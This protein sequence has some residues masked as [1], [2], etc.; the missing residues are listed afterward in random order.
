MN[1]K[2]QYDIEQFFNLSLDMLCIAGMDGYFKHINPSFERTLGWSPEEL[3]AETFF[4]FIHPD[5]LGPTLR[6]V[7]KLRKGTSSA[8]FE[9][10]YR[11]SDGSYRY[12]AWTAV[13]VKETR[14]IY[15]IARD[16]TARKE[17]EEKMA[18]L[19]TEL[20]TA[21]D[22]L[23]RLASADPLTG[24]RNRRVFNEQLTQL[25]GVIQRAGKS[26][27]LLMADVDHF[28]Q[29]NDQFGH[30]SGDQILITIAALLMQNTRVSDIVARYG[31]EEFAVI[32]PNTSAKAAILIGE[33]L[34]LAVQNHPWESKPVAV[35]I[36]ISTASFEQNHPTGIDANC[37]TKLIAEADQALYQSKTRGRNRT[38]HIANHSR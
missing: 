16:V 35:S 19:A 34:R 27:S 7:N 18:W 36:G 26:I 11:C 25:I 13:P 23:L 33:K 2:T 31:G 10:R 29:Y 6:E 38:T 9:N 15:A 20:Q 4:D 5:D 30:Q 24:L 3:L 21:N 1:D 17:T 37:S 28:K 12:L 8:R 32:L 14:L 22:K